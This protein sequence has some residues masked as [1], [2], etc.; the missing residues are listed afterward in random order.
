[1]KFDLELVLKGIGLHR[2]SMFHF[3]LIDITVWRK[4]SGALRA[5]LHFGHVE[6]LLGVLQWPAAVRTLYFGA[7]LR[8]EL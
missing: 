3:A 2:G 6:C 7:K 5:S 4:N 8:V 1:M